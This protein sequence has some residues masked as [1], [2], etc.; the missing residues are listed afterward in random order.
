MCLVRFKPDAFRIQLSAMPR[1]SICYYEPTNPTEHS[2]SEAD[3]E[4][5]LLA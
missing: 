5:V 2:P 1:G 3:H 4:V